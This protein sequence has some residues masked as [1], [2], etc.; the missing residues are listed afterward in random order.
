MI[1]CLQSHNSC[2]AQRSQ[3]CSGNSHAN[4]ANNLTGEPF[5]TN[6]LSVIVETTDTRKENA[7]SMKKHYLDHQIVADKWWLY[8][9]KN[10]K[11][12]SDL[13]KHTIFKWN[14][15]WRTNTLSAASLSLLAAII[16]RK[17]C[18]SKTELWLVRSLHSINLDVYHDQD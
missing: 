11:F 5:I 15:L 9:S 6:Y 8:L 12:Q 10:L 13:V 1:I 3:L 14:A 17:E 18:G 4:Q 16:G 2:H 7:F